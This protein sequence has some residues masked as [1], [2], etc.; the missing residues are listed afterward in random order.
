[1]KPLGDESFAE[2]KRNVLQPMLAHLADEVIP[3]LEHRLGNVGICE[4]R[5]PKPTASVM[6]SSVIIR[7]VFTAHQHRF[8]P[9]RLHIIHS[10]KFF[11]AT[12]CLILWLGRC[13]R[14]PILWSQHLLL[15]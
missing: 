8:S 14:R 11:Q 4:V 9:R 1:M 12:T 13:L 7:E 3:I 15:A 6:E 2:L 5:D 10:R